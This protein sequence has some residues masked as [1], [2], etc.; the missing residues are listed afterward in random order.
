TEVDK[1]PDNTLYK[2]VTAE[3]ASANGFLN[4]AIS[5]YER[6]LTEKP[7]DFAALNNIAGVHTQ[8][9][10]YDKALAAAK[11]AFSQAPE[12]E[13]ALDTLGYVLIKTGD[14]KQGRSYIEKALG[15]AA[16]NKEIQLHAAEALILDGDKV[17]AKNMLG[18]IYPT[19]PAQKS[20][21]KA[22]LKQLEEQE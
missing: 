3:Y 21:H 12:S 20:M 8:L 2:F 17:R 16:N 6:I 22:L 5:M 11:A 19:T 14:V 7:N 9:G 13:F 15:K 1:A 10:N 18:R 4:E